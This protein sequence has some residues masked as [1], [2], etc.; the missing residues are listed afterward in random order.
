MSSS[1][2]GAAGDEAPSPGGGG[3]WGMGAFG[4]G[5]GGCGCGCFDVGGFAAAAASLNGLTLFFVGFTWVGGFL[6]LSPSSSSSSSSSPRL[7]RFR[8]GGRGFIVAI[9]W[10]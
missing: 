6:L 8:E 5:S 2:G 4:S 10:R 9:V 1:P 7:S 3:G